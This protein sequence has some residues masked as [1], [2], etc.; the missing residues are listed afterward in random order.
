M[1]CEPTFT[2]FDNRGRT[3][4]EG[5]RVLR[6]VEPA[7]H[8]AAAGVFEKC[9]LA[10]LLGTDIVNTTKADAES[11]QF[12]HTY[13]TLSFP[14]EW[15]GVLL[16]QAA[17]F[18][19]Q[20]CRKLHRQGL[21]LKDAL[22]NNIV[23]DGCDPRFVDFLSIVETSK[24][25]EEGWLAAKSA[26]GTDLRRTVLKEMF[27][28]FFFIPLLG[29]ALGK[30]EFARTMLR[31]QACNMRSEHP[32]VRQLFAILSRGQL[33][34]ARLA[35]GAFEVARRLPLPFAWLA[36]ERLISNFRM[37]DNTDYARYYSA[38][39]EDFPLE[40]RT[41]WREKQTSVARILELDRPRSVIDFGA[42]TGWFSRLAASLGAKVTSL[43]I[44]EPSINALASTAQSQHT[45]IL[46]LRI[47]FGDLHSA[48]GH[49]GKPATGDAYFCA[50]DQRLRANCG[51][52]LGL[53]HH[54]VL[55]EN[56]SISEIIDTLSRVCER[57]AVVEFVSIDD[58]LVAGN[59]GY[60]PA[61]GRW[62]AETYSL[63]RFISEAS[64]HFPR[65]DI[66]PSHP[67]TRTIVHLRK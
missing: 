57:S 42:N 37:Q 58:A 61:I 64:T 7:H 9:R 5:D 13:H 49:D 21:T 3:W 20:L 31:E 27:A 4:F 19:L 6:A 32:D 24:L 52:M 23:F 65:A 14:H 33:L 59:P 50:P 38:K 48:V 34:K 39:G 43:D 22:P 51:V 26:P 44:D 17:L 45:D 12:E 46:P 35:W 60:F 66:L 54:L 47:A 67:G 62:T 16:K 2:G 36:I 28:P 40:D 63:D 15:P 25:A 18:H 53:I 1:G 29:H 11:H 30:H 55:G 10:G 56:R 8:A 41:E